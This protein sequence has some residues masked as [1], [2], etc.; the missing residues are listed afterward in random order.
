ML[1]GFHNDIV[2]W[3]L[4]NRKVSNVKDQID[5]LLTLGPR[6]LGLQQF[7][8]P[9]NSMKCR[10]WQGKESCGII[11]TLVVN[12]TLISDFSKDDRKTAAETPSDEMVLGAVWVLCEF[13]LLVNKQNHPNLSLTTLDNALKRF[14][15]ENSAFLEQKMLKSA[16]GKLDE[17]L[18]RESHWIQEYM[19]HTIRA[20]MEVQM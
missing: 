8:E 19:I 10:Y 2:H 1:Q 4:N 11:R 20:P 14:Y 3:L 16:K 6:Y 5:N 18:A 15:K 13:S 7:A 12:C 9:F 17:L